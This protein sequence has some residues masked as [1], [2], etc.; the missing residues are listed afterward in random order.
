MTNP[1]FNSRE[2]YLAYA[3][4][5]KKRYAELSQ[6]QRDEKKQLKQKMRERLSTYSLHNSILNRKLTATQMLEERVQSKIDAGI[7]RRTERLASFV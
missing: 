7:R 5:W 4:D 6:L 1:N 2:T 3:A